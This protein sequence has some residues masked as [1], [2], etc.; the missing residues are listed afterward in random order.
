M[1]ANIARK[2]KKPIEAYWVKGFSPFQIEITSF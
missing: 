2:K 1:M